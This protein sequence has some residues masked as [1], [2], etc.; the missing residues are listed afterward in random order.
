ML[1]GMYVILGCLIR[2]K[3]SSELLDHTVIWRRR[4]WISAIARQ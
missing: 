2:L 4:L 1:A 3:T